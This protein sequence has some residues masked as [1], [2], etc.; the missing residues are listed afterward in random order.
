MDGARL[1][2]LHH[3]QMKLA[4]LCLL[5]REH[6]ADH[7]THVR[8]ARKLGGTDVK[9]SNRRDEVIFTKRVCMPA[10]RAFSFKSP[11]PADH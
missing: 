7:S 9:D 11:V 10:D 4:A 1:G 8:E 3:R 6:L 2:V 5:C